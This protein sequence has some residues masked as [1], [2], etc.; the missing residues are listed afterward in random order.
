MRLKLLDFFASGKAVVSTNIG[1]EG[2]AARDGEEILLRNDKGSFAEAVIMLLKD[3]L[4]RK[5]LG[6]KARGLA[7][8]EYSWDSIGKRFCEV[9]EKAIV[10]HKTEK[11]RA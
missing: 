3:S 7:E 4:L 11:R 10:E 1:A 6:A 5:K 2:N 8:R 9:Y